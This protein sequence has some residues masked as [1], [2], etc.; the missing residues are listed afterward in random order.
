M[1]LRGQLLRE[2]ALQAEYMQLV[3]DNSGATRACG[4]LLSGT[5]AT[6]LIYRARSNSLEQASAQT[7]ADSERVSIRLRPHPR[8]ACRVYLG[9]DETLIF[10]GQRLHRREHVSKQGDASQ[11]CRDG[12]GSQAYKDRHKPDT[13]T[14]PGFRQVLFQTPRAQPP[15]GFDAVIGEPGGDLNYDEC[16]GM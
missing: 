16:V 6:S 15:Y 1:L 7:L 2:C 12:E 9:G 5:Q 8:L 13:G 3:P 11:R 4:R 14:L 10:T